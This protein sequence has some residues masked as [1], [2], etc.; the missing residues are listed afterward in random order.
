MLK[1]IILASLLSLSPLA[2]AGLPSS[3]THYTYKI[4]ENDIKFNYSWTDYYNRSNSIAFTLD[5]IA[6]ANSYVD[7]KRP[8][9][10]DAFDFIHNS[11]LQDINT[12]NTSQNQYTIKL[13][14]ESSTSEFEF[15]VSG[16]LNDELLKKIQTVLDQRQDEYLKDYFNKYYYLWNENDKLISIDY[17]RITNDYLPKMTPIVQ[18]FKYKNNRNIYDTRSVVNDILGFYQSI[19]YDTLLEDRGAGFSTPFKLLHEDKGDCDTKLVA[20][21][22]TVRA[23]YPNVKALAIVLP[24]HVVIAFNLPRANTDKTILYKGKPFVMAETAGPGLIPLGE[25]AT[26]SE[27][28]MKAG[29]YSIIEL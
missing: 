12:I 4:E 3:Q 14:R 20:V 9:N 13:L 8:R 18:A 1:K 23:L 26:E 5:K 17:S 22:A 2:I 16:E 28:L 15:M 21:A 27:N 6:V 11:L 7:F 24:K 19:P 29:S 25:I 10:E